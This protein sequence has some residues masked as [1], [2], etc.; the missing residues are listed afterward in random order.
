M[1][2]SIKLSMIPSG[3]PPVLHVSHGDGATVGEN[4]AL[5]YGAETTN[6]YYM[7][8]QF[9]LTEPLISGDTYTITLDVTPAS[10]VSYLGA[11]DGV[12]WLP[13]CKFYVSGTSRQLIAATFTRGK[14]IEGHDAPSVARVYRYPND[15]TVTGTTTVHRIKIERGTVATAFCPA[16]SEQTNSVARKIEIEVVDA[17][18][19]WG[20]ITG[21]IETDVGEC[22]CTLDSASNTFACIL[23]TS[24]TSH[25]GMHRAQLAL[26]NGTAV[27][28]SAV[29]LIDVEQ[30][31]KTE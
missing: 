2:Q 12:G 18:E 16:L 28:R 27:T 4:L 1:M 20:G 29:F 31:A 3:V 21:T 13:Y 7:T 19:S 9:E 8:H 23:P 26:H 11:Y 24:I 17:P 14:A 30:G 15:G 10:G 22:N 25:A 5:K 6:A